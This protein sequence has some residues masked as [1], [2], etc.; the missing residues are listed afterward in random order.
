MKSILPQI[1]FKPSEKL[2]HAHGFIDHCHTAHLHQ[3]RLFVPERA[4]RQIARHHW[5]HH[6][7]GARVHCPADSGKKQQCIGQDDL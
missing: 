7:V 3:R 4:L 1:I 5:R 6:A 2:I